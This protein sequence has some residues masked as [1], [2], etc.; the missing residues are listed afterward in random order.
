MKIVTLNKIFILFFQFIV[1][2]IFAQTIYESNGFNEKQLLI[3]N[4]DKTFIY[5]FL[6]RSCNE[7]EANLIEIYGKYKENKISISFESQKIIKSKILF[8]TDSLNIKYDSLDTLKNIVFSRPFSKKDKFQSKYNIVRYK[9]YEF[10]MEDNDFEASYQTL[11]EQYLKLSSLVDDNN[12]YLEYFIIAKLHQAKDENYDKN[13]LLRG[14]P[15]KY[16]KYY[17]VNPI[18]A[19]VINFS[20]NK[21]RDSTVIDSVPD[22]E[23]MLYEYE[24]EL[25]KGTNDGIF[26]QMVF[27]SQTDIE[28]CYQG[29]EVVSTSKSRSKAKAILSNE[30][31]LKNSIFSTKYPK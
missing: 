10:L 4:N 25:N 27:Y 9:N 22:E 8:K 17:H 5:K 26:S 31:N 16:K 21:Y 28:K 23:A 29:F 7:V 1:I 14:I 18:I 3:L 15:N 13:D 30:C 11:Q 19:Q 24:I 2:S 20:Q 6:G 12:E